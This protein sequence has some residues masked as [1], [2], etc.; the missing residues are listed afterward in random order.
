MGMSID[1]AR[2]VAVRGRRKGQMVLCGQK[3]WGKTFAQ[4]WRLPDGIPIPGVR[5][6]TTPEREKMSFMKCMS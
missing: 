2:N 6:C 4:H 5:F 1:C 3:G